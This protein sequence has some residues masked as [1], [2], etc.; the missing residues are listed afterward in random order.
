[1]SLTQPLCV[2]YGPRATSVELELDS[3]GAARVQE[4]NPRTETAIAEIWVKAY[5]VNQAD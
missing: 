3:T 4:A 1:M 2:S 5:M